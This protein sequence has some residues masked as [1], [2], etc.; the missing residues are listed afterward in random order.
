MH[1]KPDLVLVQE[2]WDGAYKAMMLE[3]TFGAAN[4]GTFAVI[5]E[6]RADSTAVFQRARVI[7][8]L[9]RSFNFLRKSLFV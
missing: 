4:L 8:D 7:L 1:A 9:T 5:F 3:V 2:K 6:Y